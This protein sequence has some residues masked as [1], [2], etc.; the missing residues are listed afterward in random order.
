[1]CRC[2]AHTVRCEN[3]D[4]IL[5][6]L[7]ACH[8][9]TTIGNMFWQKAPMCVSCHIKKKPKNVKM[10][11]CYAHHTFRT[12]GHCNAIV[13]GLV[14]GQ[15]HSEIFW[16]IATP[17]ESSTEDMLEHRPELPVEE[18]A[19]LAPLREADAFIPPSSPHTAATMAEVAGPFNGSANGCTVTRCLLQVTTHSGV[20]FGAPGPEKLAPHHRGRSNTYLQ[21]QDS[22]LGH[23]QRWSP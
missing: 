14:H 5:S 18:R 11:Y 9:L 15:P 7:V 1:M 4:L 12:K 10:S 22:Q 16:T 3:G 6:R 13:C 19:S 23:L 21:R 2:V 8:H 20:S 17:R